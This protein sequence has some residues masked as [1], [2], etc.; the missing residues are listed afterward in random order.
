MG[1]TG[2]IIKDKNERSKNFASTPNV[3]NRITNVSTQQRKLGKF[4]KYHRIHSRSEYMFSL[5]SILYKP[6]K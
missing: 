2:D 3:H 1:K 4:F 5:N 6:E